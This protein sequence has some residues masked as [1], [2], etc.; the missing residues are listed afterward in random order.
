MSPIPG[1][2]LSSGIAAAPRDAGA[3]KAADRLREQIGGMVQ[4][5]TFSTISLKWFGH[6][7]D[8][9]AMLEAVTAAGR[10]TQMR[11]MW[12]AAVLAGMVLL[13]AMALWLRRALRAAEQAGEAKSE[14]LANMRHE[15]RTPLN[16]VIGMN[17]LLLDSDLS[18]EQREFAET[19]RRSGEALL[20]V[21]NDSLDF[22][23]IEARKLVI[24]SVAFNLRQVIEEVV[25]MLQPKAEEHELD[26]TLR[27][28]PGTP[29]FFLGDTS[30]IRQVVTNLAN[31]ALK[32]TTGDT[33]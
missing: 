23:K 2:R 5:G 21:I 14:F 27:Y 15:I 33:C 1:G 24:E 19:A 10:E 11:T 3:A 6:P 25:E 32:F 29:Q 17:G 26:L 9:A 28:C 13:L 8:E 7:T 16:G 31:N 4:D 30:R 12:L 22:S 18:E 20:A